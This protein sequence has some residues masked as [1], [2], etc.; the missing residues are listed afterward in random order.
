MLQKMLVFTLFTEL[1][2]F[3]SP[4]ILAAKCSYQFDE[5]KSALT[6]TGYKFTEKMGVSGSFDLVSFKQNVKSA[7][8]SE[9]VKSVKFEVDTAS[10][11]S[12]MPVRDKKLALYLFGAMA[13]PGAIT[14]KV[15]SFDLK[16][17]SASAVITM[18]RV[19][20]AVPFQ[21]MDDGKTLTF[22]GEVDMLKFKMNKSVQQIAAACKDLHTGSDGKSKTWSVV[23]L[24]ITAPYQKICK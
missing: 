8:L 23:G 14:G 3:I 9:L 12:G 2:I 7:S 20:L 19:S 1:L 6:W 11:N 22:K 13:V 21:V 18:N 4:R 5:E 24:E 10:I 17:K 16:V 15:K